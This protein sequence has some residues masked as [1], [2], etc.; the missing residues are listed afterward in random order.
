MLSPADKV[1]E[2][3]IYKIQ[4]CESAKDTYL[5]V[6]ID[7]TLRKHG[8]LKGRNKLGWVQS[9]APTVS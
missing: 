6:F 8:M 3:V 4:K 5:S 1:I 2:S 7:Y 9:P